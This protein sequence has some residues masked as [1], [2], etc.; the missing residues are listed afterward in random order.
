MFFTFIVHPQ[1]V[2][3]LT[4]AFLSLSPPSCAAR[5]QQTAMG[6]SRTR[7][8]HQDKDNCREVCTDLALMLPCPQGCGCRPQ[9]TQ[10]RHFQDHTQRNV[11]HECRIGGRDEEH[12]CWRLADK[13]A[14]M[15][16]RDMLVPH[17]VGRR[18]RRPAPPQAL[19]TRSSGT[20][21]VRGGGCGPRIYTEPN[22]PALTRC[23]S[24]RARR[25]RR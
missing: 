7:E 18:G 2:V 4:S 19:T 9:H 21:M 8:R 23:R 16:N 1:P 15:A 22:A 10:H 14:T 20:G 3:P 12:G 6:H 13:G 5:A 11:G 17:A 24:E 25:C